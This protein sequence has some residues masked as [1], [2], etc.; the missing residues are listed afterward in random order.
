MQILVKWHVR[1]QRNV[2]FGHMIRHPKNV[3]DSQ[4]QLLWVHVPLAPMGPNFV[5]E[6]PC[7]QIV[8]YVLA[9]HTD[10]LTMFVMPKLEIVHVTLI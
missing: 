6:H 4:D 1:H 3:I 7:H 2:L 8:C 9:T 10:L 5:Q